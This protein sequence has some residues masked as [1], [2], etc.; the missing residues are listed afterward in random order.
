MSRKMTDEQKLSIVFSS[1]LHMDM[2]DWI[3]IDEKKDQLG[4]PVRD[5]KNMQTLER[6]I[7]AEKFSGVFT[8]TP[9]GVSSAT[10]K[11]VP[12]RTF[13]LGLG[14]DWTPLPCL[15]FTPI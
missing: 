9:R 4:Y 8:V 1:G 5:F 3:V 13:D 6:M 10:G 2:K 7:V 15:E 12:S 11:P 14:F